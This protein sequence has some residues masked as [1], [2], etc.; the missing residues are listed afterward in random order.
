V[1]G[2]EAVLSAGD[3]RRAVLQRQRLT[4]RVD[5]DLAA[6]VS[7]CASLQ[8]QYAPTAYIGLWSRCHDVAR[9]D[10][11]RALE[12]RDVAQG[13]MH[14]STIH[15]AAVGD[16]WPLNLAIR[17][18]RRAWYRRVRGAHEADVLA[19]AERVRDA[20]STTDAVT[21]KELDA[22][23]G[24][25]SSCVGLFADLVRV[26]PSGT[27]DRRRAD[28]FALAERWVGPEPAMST[29]EATA[30]LV[31]HY[32]G[33]FGPATANEIATWAGMTVGAITPVLRQL[34]LTE[35]RAA[36]GKLLVDLPELEVPAA[37]MPLPPRFLGPWEALLLV[38]ARRAEIL[39]EADRP[40]IF[41]T[42]TPQSY[43]TFLVDGVVAGTWRHVDGAIEVTPWRP[44]GRE[45]RAAVDDEAAALAAWHA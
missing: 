5:A 1:A 8:A 15:V 29:D 36:D 11:T 23:A 13:T 24:A 27:W 2:G 35:H 25:E 3:L 43:P 42:T 16:Y 37:S 19:A 38:H 18:S 44:L 31:R 39:A 6:V 45:Q 30:F 28:L 12:R 4:A 40:R 9:H 21:R 10:L 33:G 34:D 41:A 7:S 22:L 26:P 20:L 14:R 32:L 17:E